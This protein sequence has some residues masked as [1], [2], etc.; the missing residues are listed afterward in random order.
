MYLFLRNI[1]LIGEITQCRIRFKIFQPKKKLGVCETRLATYRELLKLRN[2]RWEFTV[3]FSPLLFMFDIF[4]NKKLF[5]KFQAA[6]AFWG[7]G[8]GGAGSS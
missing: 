8:V 6:D 1:L 2:G 5:K 3:Q 4:Q 7:E